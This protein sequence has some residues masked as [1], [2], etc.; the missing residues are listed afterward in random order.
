MVLCDVIDVGFDLVEVG[1]FVILLWFV[2]VK[3]V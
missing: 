1:E 2:G 3:V